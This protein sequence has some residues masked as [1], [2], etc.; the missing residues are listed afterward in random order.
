[1]LCVPLL[2]SHIYILFNGEFFQGFYFT[3]IL[4]YGNFY[5][6]YSFCGLVIA[7]IGVY[8]CL[9]CVAKQTKAKTL[10]Q[11][12]TQTRTTKTHLQL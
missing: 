11:T 9:V 4:F 7:F 1:M 5:F 12:Q 3:E 8:V 10:T 6:M 2:P